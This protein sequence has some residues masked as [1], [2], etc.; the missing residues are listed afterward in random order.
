METILEFESRENL[1]HLAKENLNQE[2]K[3]SIREGRI[4]SRHFE[5]CNSNKNQKNHDYKKFQTVFVVK[6][7]VKAAK[8]QYSRRTIES[9]SNCHN[10]SLL[11]YNYCKNGKLEVKLCNLMLFI[12]IFFFC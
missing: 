5:E 11:I 1:N 6:N 10:T 7:A 4:S 9:S 3:I 8:K 2:R 12:E